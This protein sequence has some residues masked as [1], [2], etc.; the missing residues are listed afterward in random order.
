MHTYTYKHA[1]LERLNNK[2]LSNNARH[3]TTRA[4]NRSLAKMITAPA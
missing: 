2:E 4:S 1:R 3:V